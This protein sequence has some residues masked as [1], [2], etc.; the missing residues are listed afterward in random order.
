MA[1]EA[2][3]FRL[4][5]AS[6]TDFLVVAIHTILYERGIYPQTSFLSARRY[7]FAVRQSRHPK[8]CEWI[9][10]AVAS[11]E[12]ELLKGTVDRI[13]VVIYSKQNK[14]LER[15]MFEVSRFPTVPTSD[16]DVP[17][18]SADVEGTSPSVLPL[19][20]LEEQMRA[21]MSRLSNCSASLDVLPKG[22][23]F[24]IAVE[25][26]GED[27]APLTH[28]QP[29]IP[30]Q[31]SDESLGEVNGKR[32]L[33]LRAVRAGEMAFETWVEELSEKAA[34]DSNTSSLP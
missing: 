31:G 29:W 20:D 12:S 25:L 11:V 14:P 13:A 1:D 6:F 33:P 8:V 28:P 3:T 34:Q 17:L 5:V 2:P 22:C 19:V 15:F 27:D 16:L 26:K 32:T 30:V 21:T 24:T 7:N 9:N 18:E 4:F 10:D 23:T